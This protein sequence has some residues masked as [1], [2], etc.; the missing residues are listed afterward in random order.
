MPE[1]N[2]SQYRFHEKNAYFFWRE[3]NPKQRSCYHLRKQ[4]EINATLE[5]WE[6][7]INL[8]SRAVLHLNQH[9][10][11]AE[12]YYIWICA[13]NETK[14]EIALKCLAKHLMKSSSQY[15]SYK[16]LALI[17][18]VF[19]G[20]HKRALSLLKEQKKLKNTKNKF[21]KEA[22][23]LFLSSFASKLAS[24]E[25][26]AK[27]Y[28]YKGIYILKRICSDSNSGYF[29]WRNCLRILSQNNFENS[30]SR[31]YN[32]MHIKFPCAQEPYLVSS[33][34][35]MN[36]KKWPEAMR[37]LNQ[38]RK[39][40]PKNTETILALCQC[41]EE[42]NELQKA[43][44][45]LEENNEYFHKKDYDYNY[46]CA[47]V[48]TKLG[49]LNKNNSYY[50]KAIVFYD[51]A[52][53]AAQILLLPTEKLTQIMNDLSLEI[54]KFDNAIMWTLDSFLSAEMHVTTASLEL[55]ANTGKALQVQL[56]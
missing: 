2:N 50:Q 23:G 48:M 14:D 38:L 56:K 28:V 3:I 9:G 4:L 35:A 11:R 41:Y 46:A 47:R 42:N 43:L 7:V 49:E 12:F 27:K 25:I 30:L 51:K 19:L 54:Q 45:L 33:L 15:S 10:E 21:Y 16:C 55:F 32:L 36:E 40:N 13:L 34:I 6:L 17:A 29:N 52:I 26:K 53:A 31:M 24:N 20:E 8:S 5:N 22:L 1:Q 39:D 37:Y 18:Y 44:Q